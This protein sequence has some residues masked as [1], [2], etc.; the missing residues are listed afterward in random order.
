MAREPKLSAPVVE[1]SDS[2]Q[3]ILS[4]PVANSEFSYLATSSD[5]YV[6]NF[7]PSA[8]AFNRVGDALEIRFGNGAVIFL[9]GY[10]SGDTVSPPVFEVRDGSVIA[11]VD[12]LREFPEYAERSTHNRP[13]S[14]E[15]PDT[16][17]NLYIAADSEEAESQKL[18]A[19]PLD[20]QPEEK[21]DTDVLLSINTQQPLTPQD[22]R[23]FTGPTQAY[24]P[25]DNNQAAAETTQSS[26]EQTADSDASVQSP[27][28]HTS[29]P[30]SPESQTNAPPHEQPAQ[31]ITPD[32]QTPP[33]AQKQPDAGPSPDAL[34]SDQSRESASSASQ[35]SGIGEYRPS[36][37]AP[38]SPSSPNSSLTSEEASPSTSVESQWGASSS[39]DDIQETVPTSP[40][41]KSVV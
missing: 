9:I 35:G 12:L 19:V 28:A 16:Q 3:I 27:L 33:L 39:H 29:D 14:Q 25:Q 24:T 11:G 37:E 18:D 8:A 31:Q 2:R 22:S 34:A 23:Q 10:F 1:S 5:K 20:A 4:A 38:A 36:T 6:L 17:A 41:R 40:D 15:I 13:D 32:G 21:P 30:S 26:G 7:E